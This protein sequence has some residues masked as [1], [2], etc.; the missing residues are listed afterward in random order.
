MTS[1][2]KKFNSKVIAQPLSEEESEEMTKLME[3]DSIAVSG[4]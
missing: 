3:A 4:N 2:K 1:T